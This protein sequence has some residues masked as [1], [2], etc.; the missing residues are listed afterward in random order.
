MNPLTPCDVPADSAIGRE[1]VEAAYFRDSYRAPLSRGDLGIVPV[2][3]AIFGHSPLVVKLLLVARNAVAGLAGLEVPS[4][5]DVM[6]FQ[7][8]EPYGVGDKIGPWPIFAIDAAEIV[9][10]RDNKHLDFRVSVLKATDQN[11]RASVTVSTVCS[12]HNLA[13]KIYLFF[14]VPFHRF[15]VQALISRAV[16]ARRL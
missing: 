15:G 16:A 3:A 12:T 8:R 7:L 9:A 1:V 2:Y 13:G 10:G 5:R 14:V 4:V 11:G 6:R